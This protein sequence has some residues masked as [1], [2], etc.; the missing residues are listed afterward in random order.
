MALD[1]LVRSVLTERA[2]NHY[3]LAETPNN[4]TIVMA[5]T[6][7]VTLNV[8]ELSF[9]IPMKSI[10]RWKLHELLNFN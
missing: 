10:G 1:L 6:S 3:K 4:S 7:T 8:F 5:V 2:V 9:S